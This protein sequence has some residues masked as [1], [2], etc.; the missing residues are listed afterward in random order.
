VSEGRKKDAYKIS[1]KKSKDVAY[2]KA[3]VLSAVSFSFC[4]IS[5]NLF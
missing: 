2:I 5:D 1:L 3:Y 4:I